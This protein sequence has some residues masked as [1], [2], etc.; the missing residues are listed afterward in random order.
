MH[1]LVS[2]L[3]GARGMCCCPPLS[4]GDKGPL[5]DVPLSVLSKTIAKT[6]PSERGFYNGL[7]KVN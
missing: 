3:F 7:P 1:I 4:G 5:A 2:A 6:L